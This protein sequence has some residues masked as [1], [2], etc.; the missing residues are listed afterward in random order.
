MNLSL[1]VWLTALLL[2]LSVSSYA[3]LSQTHA[4]A[5]FNRVQAQ[6]LRTIYS[7][8]PSEA[9]LHSVPEQLQPAL[10]G[11]AALWTVFPEGPGH[12]KPFA[13][14]AVELYRSGTLKAP[15]AVS[16][17]GL[18]PKTLVALLAANGFPAQ[19]H[20]LPPSMDDAERAIDAGRGV[21]LLANPHQLYRAVTGEAHPSS[22]ALKFA[23]GGH[24][25]RL[26]AQLKDETGKVTHYG[27]YDVNVKEPSWAPVENI[28]QIF[29]AAPHANRGIVITD[30]VMPI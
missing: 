4:Y 27:I 29:R 25:V 24:V 26:V 30:N 23:L 6:R 10:C 9:Q 22:D 3:E 5:G 12:D 21:F 15:S 14:L 19:F 16:A 20:W 7:R 11:V 2:F 28:R 8:A 13:T 18:D 17:G 1:K